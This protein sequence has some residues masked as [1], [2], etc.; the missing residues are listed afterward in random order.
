MFFLAADSPEALNRVR[1]VLPENCIFLQ[2]P[3][4]AYGRDAASLQYA[5]ADAILLSRCQRLIG[6]P[7]SS[8][9]ELACRLARKAGFLR[10]IDALNERSSV[11]SSS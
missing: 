4:D 10:T 7:Y 1:S 6:S 3:A 8:Y 5:L 11:C 9:T 2:K